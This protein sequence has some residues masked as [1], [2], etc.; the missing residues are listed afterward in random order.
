[1]K[2]LSILLASV[3]LLLTAFSSCAKKEPAAKI[4]NF[5]NGKRGSLYAEIYEGENLD[6]LSG[7]LN[8]GT[9]F[10]T[11]LSY[12]DCSYSIVY[13]EGTELEYEYLIVVDLENNTML[14]ATQDTFAAE[15]SLS[16]EVRSLYLSFTSGLDFVDFISALK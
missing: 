10:G 3:L 8:G 9:P 7:A 12:D 13:G 4:Y 2:K 1:M 5:E 6:F 14:Y 16:G 15:E 11:L